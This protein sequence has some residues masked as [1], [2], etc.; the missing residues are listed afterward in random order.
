[1]PDPKRMPFG[2]R[3]VPVREEDFEISCEDWNVYKLL[4]GGTVRVKLTVARIWRVLNEDGSFSYDEEGDPQI[5]VRHNAEIIS[6][7]N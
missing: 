7:S 2:D 1:M 3:E 4:D 6:R 5:L